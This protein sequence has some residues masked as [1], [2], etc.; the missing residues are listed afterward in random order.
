MFRPAPWLALHESLGLEP[1]PPF[2]DRPLAEHISLHAARQPETTALQFHDLAIT[3]RALDELASRFA[4]ALKGAGIGK[5][6]AVGIHLPNI[7]QYLVAVVALSRLGAIGSGVSPLMAPGEIAYQVQDANIKVLLTL[8]SLASAVLARID[9]LPPC[10]HTII[11]T[12]AADHLGKPCGDAPAIAG[13]RT[14]RYPDL[15]ADALPECAQTPVAWND[16]FMIQY[17]GGTTGRP[18]GAMLSVRNLMHNPAQCEAYAPWDGRHEVVVSAFP[19]FHMAGL[20]IHIAAIRYGCLTLLIPDPRDVAFM[21]A[22]MKHFAPTRMAAVPTLYQMLV[23]APAFSEIDFS[24]LRIALSGAA[25]LP[26]EDRKRIEAIIGPNRLSDVFGMTESGPVHVCNPPIRSKP[27]T[28]GIPV[29]GADT[30]IVDLETGTRELA[31]GEAGEIIT[32]GPQ[33]ML[34]YLNLP[35]ESARALRELDGKTWMFTGDVGFMDEE[36]YITVCDR[37]KDMLIVG[38]YKVFSV[39]VEDKLKSLDCIAQ[40][41]LIGTPD[42]RRPGNDIV[43]LHV[44]LTAAAKLRDPEVV[45]REIFDFC[46]ANMATFKVPK[47]IVLLD[48][49]PLTAVGK[50]DKK[51]LRAR[52]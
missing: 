24:G 34:G 32:S 35:Q 25:P 39:E 51:A 50:I 33:V 45:R 9:P 40:S 12:G 4:N 15:L 17:T 8:D 27:A 31:F 19:M 44:E 26:G 11:V 38:G 43:N 30:R 20:S 16:I 37:A 14:W 28:V 48:A 47:Q 29:A 42:T 36:G 49:I 18:K 22:Q 23:A 5:G 2:D 21:C 10:L 52:A 41:A 46:R 7:P 3:Y 1:P 13:V 6:D